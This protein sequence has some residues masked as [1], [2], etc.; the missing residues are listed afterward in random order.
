MTDFADKALLP[1]GMTDVLPPDASFEAEILE[2]LMAAYAS[3]GYARIKPPLIEFEESLLAGL[4]TAMTAQTFRVM[5]PV[6]QRMMGVRADMTP[7]VARIAAT[8]LANAPRPLRLSYA[9]QV[10]RVKGSQLRPERQFA[11]V[12]AELIGAAEPEADAEV[13]LMATDVLGKLG[14]TGLSVDIAMPTLVPA[15][16]K[17]FG[18]GDSTL[19]ELRRALDGKDAAGVAS[20]A[21]KLGG[22]ATEI[23]ST[24]L[25]AG[26]PANETLTSLSRLKLGNAAENERVSLGAVADILKSRAPNLS[27]TIDPVENRGFEY[28]TGV[29]YT[30]YARDV[31]GEL[32][33]G[34]RYLAE[35]GNGGEPATGF[36]LF[37]DTVLRALPKSQPLSSVYV[38]AGTPEDQTEAFRAEGWVTVMGLA[39]VDDNVKESHRLEC[40][41]LLED[42]AIQ[43]L[44]S[45][46]EG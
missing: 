44:N 45:E 46:D 25:S 23:L 3:R 31:R 29:T 39:P 17:E 37:M 5:D 20:L 15:V 7:Q 43:N 40:T 14:V 34:G 10:L 30:F 27:I 13:I 28:H 33:S 4:G 11:Q 12:G 9:G 42:G 8:R 41:H 22:P 24:L 16:C 38:P 1:A 6:S 2:A 35:N 18:V 32:G 36:T 19:A 26:G 21:G